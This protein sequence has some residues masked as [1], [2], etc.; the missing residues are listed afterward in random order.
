MVDKVKQIMAQV[1]EVPLDTVPDD[2]S[3]DTIKSWDSLRH[4]NL[5]LAMEEEFGV[6]FT[7][8]QIVQMLSLELIVHTLQEV[9]A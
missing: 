1:F 6:Q 4:M 7:D 2:A 8:E 5:V 9:A 3:P